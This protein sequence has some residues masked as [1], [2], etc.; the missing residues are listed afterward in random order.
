MPVCGAVLIPILPDEP[1]IT[2][3]SFILDVIFALEIMYL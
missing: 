1:S 2:N 3:L